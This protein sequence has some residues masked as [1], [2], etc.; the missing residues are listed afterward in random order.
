MIIYTKFL[1]DVHNPVSCFLS[2]YDE[3]MADQTF[4]NFFGGLIWDGHVLG[5]WVPTTPFSYLI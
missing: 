5:K 4:R 2:T 1:P 3:A